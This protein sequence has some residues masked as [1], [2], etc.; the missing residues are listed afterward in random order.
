MRRIPK[1]HNQCWNGTKKHNI[2]V[3]NPTPYDAQISVPS[4]NSDQA[5]KP[6]GM[7]S[8]LNRGK[9]EVRVGQTGAFIIKNKSL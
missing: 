8:Y 1:Q 6:L 2:R 5:K 4:E 9:N 7:F 3:T